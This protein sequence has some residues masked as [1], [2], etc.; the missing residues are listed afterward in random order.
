MEEKNIEQITIPADSTVGAEVLI[1]QRLKE[2]DLLGELVQ[3]KFTD[4]GLEE[5]SESLLDYS[6][7]LF[8]IADRTRNSDQ[9]S[10]IDEQHVKEAAKMTVASNQSNLLKTIILPGLGFAFVGAA[11]GK[12][13]DLL[14]S[15]SPV[16]PSSVLTLMSL[17][18]I[19]FL[20]ILFG[21]MKGRN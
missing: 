20:T 16:T 12:V 7:I 9:G 5:Y 21:L 8:R 11:M 18:V 1:Q 19:G 15:T 4:K 6:A 10:L 13:P 2:S 14:A 3:S 17:L